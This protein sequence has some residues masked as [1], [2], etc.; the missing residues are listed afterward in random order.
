M[1]ETIYAVKSVNN[2]EVNKIFTS[3][4]GEN[5][6][7][8]LVLGQ[9]AVYRSFDNRD[10]AV[11]FLQNAPV[12]A[13]QFGKGYVPTQ[14]G[15]HTIYGRYKFDRCREKEN[16]FSVKIYETVNGEK[17]C[18]VGYHLPNNARLMYAFTGE[19]QNNPK[20]GYEFVVETYTE[21]ISS[22]KNDI[23][24]YLSC[25]IIKGIGPKKAELIYEMFKG[26]SLEILEKE[27]ERLLKI[28]GISHNLLEKIV[29]SYEESR[30][31]REIIYFLLKYGISQK[32]GMKIYATYGTKA[33]DF[34]KN[35]PYVISE[36]RGLT[37]LDADRIAKDIKFPL[38]SIERFTS[39]AYYVMSQ[40][41]T[42]GNTGM[43]AIEFQR[44]LYNLL[45]SEY[46]S[47]QDIFTNTCKLIESKKFHTFNIEN[48]Y[49]KTTQ[50]VFTHGLQMVEK[51]IAENIVR[52][53]EQPVKVISKNIL[54]E[55]IWKA[56]KKFCISL[57]EIQRLAVETAILSNIC[58]ITGGP[59]SGKTTIMKII[60]EVY[61]QL[62][63]DN[64]RI[65]LAPTGRAARKLSE[66]TKEEAFTGHS[67]LHIFEE[68]TMRNAEND[69]YIQNALVTVDEFS[70]A[71]VFLSKKLFEVAINGCTYVLVGDID[72]LPSVGPGAVLRDII[73][74]ETVPVVRL[75]KI[76][77]QGED[78]EIYENSKKIK[79]GN[80]NLKEGSDFHFYETSSTEDAKHLMAE[81]YM[82]RVKEYGLENVMCLCPFRDHIAGVNDMNEHIQSLIN[83]PRADKPEVTVHKIIYR[84]GDLVMHTKDNSDI[85]ANG[86]IG[87]IIAITELYDKDGEVIEE[88]F[89]VH[90]EIN[91][92]IAHYT[93]DNIDKLVLAYATTVHKSQG[94]EAKAVV[95]CL[96][97][98]HKGMLY[99]NIPYVAVSRGRLQVDAVGE[100]TAWKKAVLNEDPT[101]TH[102]ITLTK[103]YLQLLSGQFV[104][105]A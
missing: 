82:K 100:K 105:T 10:D 31:S 55:L 2:K 58:V 45:G 65:F 91:G 66:S 47:K 64:Q 1:P 96:M 56:E 77:R 21:H 79:E 83:P 81:M 9:K 37:Y 59:G 43:D 42:S 39:C 98:F 87:K 35:N 50:Y 76:Y 85:A 90:V 99:R 5:G 68:E 19:F 104:K 74:S 67:Y 94:S 14:T 15:R 38:N 49:G 29:K 11:T 18:C 51:S 52:I 26:K 20:F 62:Y 44:T 17:F 72:Q 33:L 101:K 36:V 34:I 53:K 71:D 28:K 69:V 75:S 73:E 16:G 60:N 84:L 54:H 6:C 86:D 12:I 23:I 78:T 4:D 70:M 32:Y 93:K 46:F 30:T 48:V 8:A 3:W 40:N 95:I 102:R 61:K 89:D 57:D 41:E 7:K 103:Y 24:N 92:H 27:P 97:E 80:I 13:D 63:K 22:S 25:G 88:D